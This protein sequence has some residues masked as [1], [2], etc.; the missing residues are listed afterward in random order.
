M[1]L[2]LETR[3][4]S[5]EDELARAARARASRLV[6]G[7]ALLLDGNGII[8]TLTRAVADQLGAAGQE[9][10]ALPPLPTPPQDALIL[11]HER[12][13]RQQPR[14]G[15]ATGRAG[16]AARSLQG[17]DPPFA[18]DDESSSGSHSDDGEWE[19]VHDA[20]KY[21]TPATK[22]AS[23]FPRRDFD[24]VAVPK[25]MLLSRHPALVQS[26][27]KSHTGVLVAR[28]HPDANGEIDVFL[29]RMSFA[30][31]IGMRLLYHG[32]DRGRFVR[33]K[34]VEELLRAWSEREG[35]RY[36]APTNAYHKI[37]AFIRTYR[38]DCSEL[39]KTNLA[40]Y[41]TLNS[42]FYR[43]LR[44]DARPIAEPKN[45]FIVSSAA[46]CRLTVFRNVQEAHK[47]WI[48]G[49]NFSLAE[50]LQ[51][52][53]LA[54]ELDGGSVAVFRLAPADYHRFHSPVEG[55]MGETL[56]V[57]G[58]Y[59][60]VNSM[61]V[62]D[63]RFDV[64][65]ANKRDAS[66]LKCRHPS[67]GLPTRVAFVQVGALLVASIRQT[68]QQGQTLKRGDEIGY[69]AY[70]GSTIVAVFPPGCVKWNEDLLRNSEGRNARGLPIE[71]LVKVGEV[72]GSWVTPLGG[73]AD[74]L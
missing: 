7:F 5:G 37:V 53:K 22:A 63:Q 13:L 25:L 39:A 42:F 62:R 18:P 65:T 2:E 64:F 31:R 59:Y 15:N 23:L 60:T 35:R 51:D 41:P 1:G 70:G 67:T 30:T 61:I 73:T 72:I 17:M 74:L 46:D 71:T 26:S 14:L 45:P 50:L 34:R 36:D 16:P 9:G 54:R 44:R 3:V 49:R 27:I 6:R 33:S 11:L 28:R 32:V 40:D 43:R 38:I 69:F 19:D 24:R 68:A 47:L 12:E 52:S 56:H 58:A 8:R 55:T 66:I 10:M 4:E 21:S 57:P 20:Q 48:K 29:E